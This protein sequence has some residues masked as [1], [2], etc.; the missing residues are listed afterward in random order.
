VRVQ[1][2]VPIVQLTFNAHE[3]N[4]TEIWKIY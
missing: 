1:H 2:A 4:L 3:V